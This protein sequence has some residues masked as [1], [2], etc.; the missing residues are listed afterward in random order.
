M[1]TH[2]VHVKNI[3]YALLALAA[4]SPSAFAQQ[5]PTGGGLLQ[6]PAPPPPARA[7]PGIRIE[8]STAP[9]VPAGAQV[10][11]PVNTL[12]ITGATVYPEAQLL[13]LTGFTP[14]RELSLADL[15]GMAARITDHYRRSG[16]F[17]ATA[18][19]PQ[20]E[21][22]NGEVALAVTEGRLGQVTLRNRTNLADA[23]A[24]DS[25]S[26]L[27][28]GQPLALAPVE[29]GLLLLSD[30][31][32]VSVSSV[33]VPGSAPGTSDLL[34]DVAPGRRITGSVDADNAGNRYTGEYRLGAT[35]NLNN[36]FGRGDVASLR[37]LTSGSGLKYLRG[38]YQLQL[39][40]A[41]AGI[42][43]SRLEYRLG[44]EFA[45]LDAHGTAS[46]AS[47]YGRYPLRR[48]RT[49]NQYL[50][51][52]LDAKRFED[53]VDA[54]GAVSN[55]HS[56]VLTASLYGDHTDTWGGGGVSTYLLG[57]S[58]GSLDIRTPAV[59]AGDALT[60]RTDGSFQKLTFHA[61]RIQRL[62][63]PFS[64]YGSIGGQY[65]SRNL[66]V[67]EKMQLGGMNGVRAYPEGEAYADQ[68]LLATVEGRMDL[69]RFADAM[70]GRM[71]LVA[72]ADTGSVTTNHS[73]WAAGSNHRSLSGAG[74]GL[75]WAEP[76]NFLV[77]AYYA[78]KVGNEA[79]LS[80]PDKSGRFWVQ[81]VKYF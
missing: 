66:D 79:P 8:P 42:A 67:S 81:L 10:R 34:V 39:G 56:H 22:R 59:R 36:P 33:L 30:I 35:V 6:L 11:I 50:Q 72:F 64:V 24:R 28:A 63:G 25:L 41:Q 53:R 18:F 51:L 9:A 54:V 4:S 57:L 75:N 12:R 13:A 55:R 2:E 45:A 16:Y 69:P 29:E 47:V 70:P 26:G 20:Q 48:S 31:P 19:V 1:R 7:E 68:G 5:P 17:V 49:D 38:S 40:R 77:R 37:A 60:A 74:V 61:M 14:G 52:A 80:A 78:R 27:K 3:L 58:A 44:R 73:P 23:V 21:I 32:G 65:A 15:E 43:Y 71:Q 62:G 46:I 76:G